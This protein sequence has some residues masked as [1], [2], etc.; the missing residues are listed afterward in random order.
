MRS[1]ILVL[2]TS[3]FLPFITD[4]QTGN[5]RS[6][7]NKHYWKNRKPDGAYWQQDVHYR[8]NARIDETDNRI[9][10]D[11]NLEYVNNSPDTL[12]FV[13]FHLYQNA[14]IKGSYLHDL[15]KKTN[16]RSRL[17]K[18]EAAGLGTI[19]EDI[20]VDGKAAKTVLD[21][22]ILKV[23]LNKP[24]LPGGTATISMN[25]KTWY[26]NGGTRR[27]MQMYNAWGF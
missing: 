14:F 5:Y 26:D 22:T 6:A 2:F 10:A 23:F 11:E 12:T 3:F 8:I 7:Q 19:V 13:Y 27:R 1:F 4:A 25:F 16:F 24:L 18:N 20:K 9:D 21:N 17:G 15:E